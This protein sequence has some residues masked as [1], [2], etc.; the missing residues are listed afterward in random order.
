MEVI[1]VLQLV[2]AWLVLVLMLR[3]LDRAPFKTR[4]VHD[5]TLDLLFSLYTPVSS[6][7]HQWYNYIILEIQLNPTTYSSQF[8]YETPNHD[9]NNIIYERSS[10]LTW[11]TTYLIFNLDLV[12]KLSSFHLYYKFTEWK[13]SGMFLPWYIILLPV[14][15]S[16][17]TVMTANSIFF[18]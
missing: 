7:S 4:F 1:I 8:R 17:V 16:T 10:A 6:T 13:P 15:K 11:L 3:Y 2:C 14:T 5:L 9:T 12:N 18:T